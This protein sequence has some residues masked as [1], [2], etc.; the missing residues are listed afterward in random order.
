MYKL[1]KDA[2]KSTIRVIQNIETNSYIPF[3][4][5]NYDFIRFKNEIRGIG[6]ENKK[7]TPV[8]LQDVDGNTMTAEEVDGFI[9][10]LS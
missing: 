4:N 2:E 10:T 8:E 3:D 6:T 1:I 7:I 9:A 5:G